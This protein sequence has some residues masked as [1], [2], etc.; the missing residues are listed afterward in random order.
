MIDSVN[1]VAGKY[2][3]KNKPKPV[4]NPVRD[5]AP[6][7]RFDAIAGKYVPIDGSI[8]VE[9]NNFQSSNLRVPKASLQLIARI[10][11]CLEVFWE[12]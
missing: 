6:K 11:S 9:R 8:S 2:I 7:M 5:S 1:A 10:G 3:P 12:L 4:S